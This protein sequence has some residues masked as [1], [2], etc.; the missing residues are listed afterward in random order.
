MSQFIERWRASARYWS[1]PFTVDWRA[2]RPH[3]LIIAAIAIVLAMWISGIWT[4]RPVP[5]TVRT[6]CEERVA[7]KQFL[8]LGECLAQVRRDHLY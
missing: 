6:S 3:E 5:V 4:S 7:A 8:D 1:A 2:L